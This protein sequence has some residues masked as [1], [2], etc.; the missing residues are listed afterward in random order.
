VTGDWEVE[1]MANKTNGEVGA[2]IEFDGGI[3]PYFIDM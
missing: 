3:I 2:E 1:E